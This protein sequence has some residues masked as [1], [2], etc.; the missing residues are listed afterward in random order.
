MWHNVVAE[1]TSAQK[2]FD[3]QLAAWFRI[4]EINV[5]KIA[6]AAN[7]QVN[8][9]VDFLKVAQ[10]M[11]DGVQAGVFEAEFDIRRRNHVIMTITRCRT[12][13]FL[14]KRAPERIVS[15]CHGIDIPINEKYLTIFLPDA[16]FP[17]LK[18]PDGP[19]KSPDEIPCIWEL[20]RERITAT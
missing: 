9:I 20:R 4:A 3:C 8:D 10:V 14:E 17:P 6:K 19:R 16:K 7:I 12:L 18:L 13:E 2:A 1:R 5:P 15:I 11:P